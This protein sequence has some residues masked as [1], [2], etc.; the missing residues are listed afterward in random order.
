[1]NPLLELLNRVLGEALDPALA[2]EVALGRGVQVRSVVLDEQGARIVLLLQPPAGEG[3]LVLR[4]Q[5]EPPQGERQSLALTLEQ[6]P[7]HWH[8]ALEP[9]RRVLE[10]A[11]LRL[12]LDFSP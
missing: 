3:E 6:P 12:E 2:G 7:P 1:V 9:L 4:L 11:R 8:P 5:A 10:R